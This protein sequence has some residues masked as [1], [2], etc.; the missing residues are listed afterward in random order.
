MALAWGRQTHPS[1]VP[2][3]R[4]F[5][6]ESPRPPGP[7]HAA[8]APGAPPP[9]TV[10]PPPPFLLLGLLQSPHFPVSPLPPSASSPPFSF[11]C[12]PVTCAL[13]FL[14]SGPISLPFSALPP[15]PR[16]S[17]L[18]P[19][20]VFPGLLSVSVSASLLAPP[21]PSLDP[22]RP[23]SLLPFLPAAPH[24]HRCLGT[25]LLPSSGQLPS[26]GS[27]AGSPDGRRPPPPPPPA[28]RGGG[29][30]WAGTIVVGA[31]ARF[32]SRAWGGTGRV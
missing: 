22:P 29:V 5:L 3:R 21:P 32:L 27:V 4:G 15:L 10:R 28:S 25:H 30:R 26:P 31:G 18:F 6:V 20:G 17:P 9:S 2:L 19:G 16:S 14:S 24:P 1:P 12:L 23:Q 8:L 11:S 13:S 7:S